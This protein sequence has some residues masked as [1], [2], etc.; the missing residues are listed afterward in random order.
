MDERNTE[1]SY[2]EI[3]CVCLINHL[4]V[5]IDVG[6]KEVTMIIYIV[7]RVYHAIFWWLHLLDNINWNLVSFK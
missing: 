7:Q 4:E 1:S 5:F 2:W 3:I 6:L